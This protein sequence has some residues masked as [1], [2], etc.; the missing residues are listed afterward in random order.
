MLDVV[1]AP[2]IQAHRTS[3]IIQQ[4]CEKKKKKSHAIRRHNEQCGASPRSGLVIFI[5]ELVLCGL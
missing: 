3:I 5:N 2:R 1:L 4:R